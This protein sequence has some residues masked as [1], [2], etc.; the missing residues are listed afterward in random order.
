MED[1]LGPYEANGVRVPALAQPRQHLAVHPRILEGYPVIA[2]SR[3]PFHIVAALADEGAKPAE[4]V[5]IYPSVDP[6]GVPDAQDFARDV[7]R[8]AA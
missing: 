7:A 4:I 8:A 5:E 1:V 2:G 6:A 3:V